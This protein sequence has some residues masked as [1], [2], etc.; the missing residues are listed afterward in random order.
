MRSAGSV[1]GCTIGNSIC[2]KSMKPVLCDSFDAIPALSIAANLAPLRRLLAMLRKI[3][4]TRAKLP[5]P[6]NCQQRLTDE[7]RRYLLQERGLAESTLVNYVLF[8]EQ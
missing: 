8:A 2:T 5:E 3:E 7:Y 6:R 4:V 1:T